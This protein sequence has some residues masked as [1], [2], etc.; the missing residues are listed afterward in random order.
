MYH[1]KQFKLIPFKFEDLKLVTL[2]KK[3]YIFMKKIKI[4]YIELKSF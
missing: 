1:N 2:F 3:M 4:I